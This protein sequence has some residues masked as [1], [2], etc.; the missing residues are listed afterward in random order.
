MNRLRTSLPVVLANVLL[1][2]SLH[3]IPLLMDQPEDLTI[4]PGRR[5]FVV[6][7][8]FSGSPN[9]AYWGVHPDIS[10]PQGPIIA[11]SAGEIYWTSPPIFETRQV[12]FRLCDNFGCIDTRTVTVFVD[13]ADSDPVADA[14]GETMELGE[15][16]VR[17]DWLGDFNSSNFPWIFHAQHSWTYVFEESAPDNVFLFDLSSD[18]WLF[19]SPA[20]Y[21]NLFSFERNS[22]VF[23]FE[24]TV[25]PRQF[26]DLQSGEFFNME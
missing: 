2:V 9:T 4:L 17:S 14:L 10:D 15:G 25:G 3:A 1:G 7:H 22:W 8:G 24:G 5:A 19:T 23:Y 20:T 26:V 18:G 16:W 13:A 21:P 11:N 6:I 12:W